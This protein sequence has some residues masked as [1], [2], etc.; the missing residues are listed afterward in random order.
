M[1]KVQ[2]FQTEERAPQ[3]GLFDKLWYFTSDQFI[4]QV[5]KN[6]QRE[7]DDELKPIDKSRR[8]TIPQKNEKIPSMNFEGS[9]WVDNKSQ[10]KALI[11]QLEDTRYPLRFCYYTP[12]K[13]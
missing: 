5:L 7:R 13:D 11:D 10:A 9:L 3:V 8:T 6:N 2:A 12:N 4:L 1:E